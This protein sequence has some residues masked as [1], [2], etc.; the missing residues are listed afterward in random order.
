M[1]KRHPSEVVRMDVSFGLSYYHTEPE[2]KNTNFKS[3]SFYNKLF[4]N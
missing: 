3:F 2:L 1:K 4:K